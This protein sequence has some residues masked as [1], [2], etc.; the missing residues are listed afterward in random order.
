MAD[1]LK[2]AVNN[3]P[4]SSDTAA[5]L[6]TTETDKSI[7]TSRTPAV[8]IGKKAVTGW[9]NSDVVKQLKMIGI[10]R[11]MSIQD[12]LAEALNDFFVKHGK[13]QIAK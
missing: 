2:G 13:S 3:N 4:K 10:D 8:R 1:A 6:T 12:M 11:D 9:F 5:S 7:R